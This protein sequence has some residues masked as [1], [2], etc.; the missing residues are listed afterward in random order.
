MKAHW[1]F[2]KRSKL[3]SP[4]ISRVCILLEPCQWG[5]ADDQQ[6]VVLY[7]FDG[8]T[9]RFMHF[10]VL[11]VRPYVARLLSRDESIKVSHYG[12]VAHHLSCFLN[13][14]INKYVRPGSS[15]SSSSEDCELLMAPRTVFSALSCA[16]RRVIHTFVRI[17]RGELWSENRV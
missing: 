10:Q 13:K 7:Y 11:C 14:H 2:Q 3:V 4:V 12:G 8:A 6:S 16:P 5:I 17:A 1:E 9:A 15:S